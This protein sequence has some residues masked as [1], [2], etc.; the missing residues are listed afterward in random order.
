M[1]SEN[2][3]KKL[4]IFIKSME[5]ALKSMSKKMNNLRIKDVSE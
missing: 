3:R 4:L 1:L 5:P 2:N